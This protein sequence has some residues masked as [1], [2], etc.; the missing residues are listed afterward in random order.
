[1]A[2]TILVPPFNVSNTPVASELGPQVAAV[3]NGM[4]AVTWTGAGTNGTSE[5]FI[6]IYDATG[7]ARPG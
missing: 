1:M 7:K 5:E 2:L 3:G 4:F 6:A